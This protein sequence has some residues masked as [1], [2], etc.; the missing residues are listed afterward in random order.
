M[1]I[2]RL[3]RFYHTV[4]YLHLQQIFYRFYYAFYRVSP[5]SLRQEIQPVRSWKTVWFSPQAFHS[6]LTA[7]GELTFLGESGQVNFPTIWNDPNRS[8]LWLYNLHYF[9]ELNRLGAEVQV[10]Q[11]NLLIDDWMNEN[12]PCRGIGWEP[13]PLSLRIVNFV[14]WFSRQNG[15]IKPEWIINLGMQVNA[16]ERQLEYHILANHLF[17]NAKALVFAGT[18]FDNSHAMQWLEKGL[19][20]LDQELKVQFLSDGGHFELSP[21]YHASLLWDLCDLLNLAHCSGLKILQQRQ[22]QWCSLIEKALKWL[23]TML[24]PD[25]KISFFNDAAFAIAPEFSALC[26]FAKYLGCS[27]PNNLSED[28]SIE[29]LKDSGYC[30]LALGNDCKAI[31]DVAKIGPDYQPGH[32]HADTLSFELSLFSNRFIVNSG[33]SRYGE[34]K[35][36]QYERS[37]K[38]HNTVNLNGTNSSDVWAGFRVAKRAYPRNLTV[39]KLDENIIVNCSH[40]GYLYA[41][42]YN[43]HHRAWNFSKQRLIM[44]DLITGKHADA[45]SRLHFHP[46]I[47]LIMD[48]KTTIQG[49]LPSGK[50]AIIKI[51]GASQVSIEPSYWYP[52]FGI[53]LEN[54]C[55]V[56]KFST[57]LS[58]EIIW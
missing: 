55:L 42:G 32:A 21:M 40:D 11:L 12:P 7:T 20:I 46:N 34:C 15:N 41:P 28:F 1:R 16:L 2:Q 37:T 54:H 38:A 35:Q 3:K 18:Y 39:K 8:K 5:A 53:R 24:H 47:Q 49:V 52:S 19:K 58:T 17:A 56:T 51:I 26:N 44:R 36:R 45:E 31:L 4:K 13:Y 9:D 25:G 22:S 33:T 10:S 29:W 57:E 50:T 27:F 30:V 6:T 48:D 43:T 14:K 23:S